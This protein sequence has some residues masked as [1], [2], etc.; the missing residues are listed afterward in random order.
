MSQPLLFNDNELETPESKPVN[1]RFEVFKTE[2]Q[3][4]YGE[5]V[6]DR[7]EKCGTEIQTC[8]DSV[9]KADLKKVKRY[10]K[11]KL[12]ECTDEYKQKRIDQILKRHDK[13]VE[14]LS[15]DRFR[16]ARKTGLKVKELNKRLKELGLYHFKGDFSFS[17]KR[18]KEQMSKPS[19]VKYLEVNQVDI[20]SGRLSMRDMSRHTGWHRDTIKET[21]DE[22]D[23]EYKKAD[24]ERLF[25]VPISLC[26]IPWTANK[27]KSIA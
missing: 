23:L 27:I 16:L 6:K 26:N 14:S 1:E 10:L 19:L 12:V 4:K 11:Q 20:I 13:D 21:A 7:I 22:H 25:Q 18:K 15:I 8:F 24:T 5:V 17:Y 3:N 9:A 2:Y